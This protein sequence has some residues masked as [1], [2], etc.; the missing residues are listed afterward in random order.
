MTARPA[1]IGRVVTATIA[2]VCVLIVYDGW[3]KLR[4]LDVVLIILGPIIAVFT[5]HVFSTTL[6]LEV[7]LGRGPTRREWLANA[8]RES[9]YLLLALPPLAL[10][11]I[12]T[13]A[14]VPLH[15]SIRAVI[16]METLSLAFW[17]GLAAWLV[18][19]RGRR[20]VWAVLAGLVVGS[21]VVA[22][23]VTLQPGRAL[24]NGTA[25]GAVQ[26][27]CFQLGHSSLNCDFT[28]SE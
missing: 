8:R 24:E 16:W 6:V 14:T 4:L 20:L 25:V 15:D 28:P 3:A 18:G 2:L 12:L 5:S 13:L 21:V 19:M 23:Q 1:T 27:R 7:E 11:V 22:L 17:T 10:L 9:R 26:P